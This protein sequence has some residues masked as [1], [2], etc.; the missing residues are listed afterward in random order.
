MKRYVIAVMAAVA[1][2]LP[3]AAAQAEPLAIRIWG[4]PALLGIAET[5][6]EAYRQDHPEVRFEFAMRGSDSAIHGLVGGV[7][8][9]ALMGR[10]N[11][12]VD[13]NGFSRPKQ[14]HATRIEVA[15]GSVGTPGK[16]HAIALLVHQ[17]NPLG[18]ISLDQLAR[19]I[20]CGGQTNPL[21]NWGDLGLG[22]AWQGA[23]IRVH[24]FDMASRTGIWLQD[25]V[26]QGDRRMCWDRIA[27]YGEA[28]RLDG[29]LAT[30]VDRAAQGAAGD[31]QALLIANAAQARE[32]FKLL[33]VSAGTGAALAPDAATVGSRRYPLT[34]KVF[35]FVDRKPG[36]PLAPHL[37]G[38]LRYVLSR[39]GQALLERDG[40]YLPLD[41]ATARAQLEKL[42]VAQ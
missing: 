1:L 42:E 3:A 39:G 12:V 35:A 20:D 10:E 27:E 7:A 13:D 19:I 36:R 29:T 8:D 25:K 31:P 4:T 5:W 24:T 22:G 11:D 34:R 6:A 21:Q 40:D 18:E 41:E 30:A 9:I 38:F 37:A 17:G 33:K 32:G 26:T 2:V 14:Y 28:Y 15:T 16:S 23:A